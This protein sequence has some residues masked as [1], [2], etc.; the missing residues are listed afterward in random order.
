MDSSELYHVKQQFILGAYKSLAE[1]SL[2]SPSAADY[3]P[4]LLYKARASIALDDPQ[5]AL[6]LIPSDTENVALKAVTAL[7]QYVDAGGE[8]ALEALRDLCVE[9]EADEESEERE[10]DIVRVVAATA[11]A[12][13]GEVEEALETLSGASENLEAIAATVLIYLSISRPDLA[14]KA[15]NAAK[16]WAEDDLL[17]QLI[18][19]SIGLRTGTNAYADSAAFYTEQ[20]GNPSVSSAHLLTARGIVR[21]L[22][23]EV[24]EARSDLEEALEQTKGSGTQGEVLAGLV[25]ALG[26]GAG[27]TA[28]TE[29][30]WGRLN[31][32]YSSH[33]LVAD[34]ALKA[35]SFDDFAAKFEVPPPAVGT[36]A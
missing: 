20:L 1:L 30:I 35:S 3:I 29:E 11:F 19:S 23:G 5:S 17:L 32:E 14:Q 4:T 25:V 27:K 36:R 22:R 31:A 8:E 13:V 18:E 6:A 9:I 24:V 2:P 26:L 21:I 10:K 34:V 33:P 28:E 16:K 15:F 12:R 7:A